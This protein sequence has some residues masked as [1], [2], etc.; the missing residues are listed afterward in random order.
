MAWSD[1]SNRAGA[2]SL[3][4]ALAYELGYGGF[5]VGRNAQNMIGGFLGLVGD[6]DNQVLVV[7]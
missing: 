7:A 3:L 4:T 5:I 6:G 1:Y 2:S